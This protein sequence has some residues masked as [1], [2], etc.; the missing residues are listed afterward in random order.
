MA[1]QYKSDRRERDGAGGRMIDGQQDANYRKTEKGRSSLYYLKLLHR[2]SKQA[3]S[4]NPP[5]RREAGSEGKK[6][7]RAVIW[8]KWTRRPSCLICVYCCC[9][10]AGRALTCSRPLP[11]ARALSSSVC[12]FM[13]SFRVVLFAAAAPPASAEVS[14]SFCTFLVHMDAHIHGLDRLRSRRPSPVK[15]NGS[16][17]CPS[18][19]AYVCLFVFGVALAV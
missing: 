15:D 1:L 10:V 16:R 19:H 2:A 5:K 6:Q 11:P 7:K 3:S 4:T 14:T 13:C 12:A 9:L 8:W 17:G 18:I